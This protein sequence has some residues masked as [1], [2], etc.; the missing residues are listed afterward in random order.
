M[1]NIL[2]IYIL[3]GLITILIFLFISFDKIRKLYNKI[4][5]INEDIFNLKQK[6]REKI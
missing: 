5:K 4:E 3:L 6:M 1:N 2:S